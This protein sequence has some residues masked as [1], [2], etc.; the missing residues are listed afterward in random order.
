VVTR[1]G[2][3]RIIGAEWRAARVAA[4]RIGTE[5]LGLGMPGRDLLVGPAT[6][7][8][9]PRQS[10][11]VEA[12]SLVDGLYVMAEA[13]RCLTLWNLVFAGAQVVRAEGVE[14]CQ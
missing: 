6:R 5:A 4:V 9:L 2:V 8:W 12:F 7:L 11:P 3:K 14:V 1:A 10:R 13:P